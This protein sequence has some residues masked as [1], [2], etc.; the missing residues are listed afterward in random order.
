MVIESFQ[1]MLWDRLNTVLKAYKNEQTFCL[2]LK[3]KKYKVVLPMYHKAATLEKLN[4]KIY[5]FLFNEQYRLN[6]VHVFH[7]RISSLFL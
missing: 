3:D 5:W 2:F 6:S 1:G 4:C 7:F